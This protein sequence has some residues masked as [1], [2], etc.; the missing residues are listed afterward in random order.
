MSKSKWAPRKA[1]LTGELALLAQYYPDHLSRDLAKAFGCTLSQLYKQA[2]QLGLSKS[3]EFITQNT[4]ENLKKPGHGFVATQFKPGQVP[5]NK[6]VKGFCAPGSEKG[7]FRKGHKS[8]NYLEVG[9]LR[10]N[11][12][13][14]LDIKL[15]DG[16][17]GWYSLAMYSWFLET[18]RYPDPG[19]CLRFKDGDYHNTQYE[20]LQL[21]S[22]QDN[23]R[24]NTIQ[25]YPQE[26]RVVMQLGGRLRNQ[27]Q[28]SKENQQEAVHG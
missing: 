5:P 22:R 13:G 4:K 2:N 24:L 20:N 17:R 3:K 1:W 21:I 23:M 7:H 8:S 10:I 6:G 26:L 11:G 16:L 27:I 18:G 12:D 9:S 15:H 19:M 28:K 14:Y 25:R